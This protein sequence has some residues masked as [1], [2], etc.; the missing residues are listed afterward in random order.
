MAVDIKNALQYTALYMETDPK[1]KFLKTVW[2]LFYV[3]TAVSLVAFMWPSVP[4]R[5]FVYNLKGKVVVHDISGKTK[6]AS[7]NDEIKPGWMIETSE[8]SMAEVRL[9]DGSLLRIG[10]N[11]KLKVISVFINPMM[12]IRNAQWRIEST[13]KNSGVY[14]STGKTGSVYEVESKQFAAVISTGSMRV[15]DDDKGNQIVKVIENNS[16]A[17]LLMGDKK[18][19]IP[20]GNQAVIN[21]R[22][23]IITTAQR[24]S[25]D[26]E[27]V[28][29]DKPKLILD[30]T[31][32]T[33]DKEIRIVGQTG[34]KTAI[35]L[36]GEKYADSDA[37]GNFTVNLQLAIGKV[38]HTIKVVDSAGRENSREIAVERIGKGDHNLSVETP[39]SGV[40]TSAESIAITGTIQGS[41]KLTINDEPVAIY[42]NRFNATKKLNPGFNTFHIKSTGKNNDIKEVTIWLTRSQEKPEAMLIIYYPLRNM[43]TT[44]STIDIK[45][46]TSAKKIKIGPITREIPKGDF[47]ISCPLEYGENTIEVIA[48]DD[49]HKAVSKLITVTRNIPEGMK[50]DIKLMT[51]P[52]VTNSSSVSVQGTV[53]KTISLELDGKKVDFETNGFFFTKVQLEKEGKNSFLLKATSKDNID[54]TINIDIWKDSTPPD[55]TKIKA[56]K[57]KPEKGKADENKVVVRGQIEQNCELYINGVK[58]GLEGTGDLR[59]VLHVLAGYANKTVTLKAIDKAGNEST[60][61]IAIYEP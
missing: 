27:N 33:M 54:I 39:K 15:F 23:H 44:S 47:T 28:T 61:E 55:L 25:I 57:I 20:S 2:F 32:P 40:T 1:R 46:T 56:T 7:I 43:S 37:M 38:E 58:V 53:S 22:E 12:G 17:I 9:N 5:S 24:D 6:N 18:V 51:Y 31:S 52:A 29:L 19:E 50:P 3:I 16:K 14:V 36:D 35:Y 48:Q 4:D 49:D 45:G 59:N 21:G 60:R 13:G 41:Q 26:D 42:G 34:L 10:E 30:Y 11:T 8:K